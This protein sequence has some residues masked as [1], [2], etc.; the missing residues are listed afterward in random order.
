MSR[1]SAP[2]RASSIA[3]AWRPLVAASVWLV[4]S[5]GAFLTFPM[6]TWATSTLDQSVLAFVHPLVAAVLAIGLLSAT[7]VKAARQPAFWFR[8]SWALLGALVV[9]FFGY[10]VLQATWTCTY[11]NDISLVLGW[12]PTS[13]LS[14][15]MAQLKDAPTCERLILDF[16]GD[17]SRMYPRGEIITRFTVLAVVYVAAWTLLASLAVSVANAYLLRK[18]PRST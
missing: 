10:L 18:A 3:R 6:K 5:L 4:A 14:A 17:T 11:A 2:P 12:T 9:A 15:Y 1:P 8:M 7:H 16:A 13:D